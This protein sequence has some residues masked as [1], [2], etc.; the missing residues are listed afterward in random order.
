M[1]TFLVIAVIFTVIVVGL[2]MHHRVVEG[3]RAQIQRLESTAA[4]HEHENLRLK[5]RLDACE[6][7]VR[8]LESQLEESEQARRDLAS[9]LRQQN[10]PTSE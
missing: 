1:L 2:F 9:Q 3:A 5:G 8:D 7:K 4:N 6:H 10:A